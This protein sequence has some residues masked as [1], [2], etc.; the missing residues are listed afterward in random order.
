[1]ESLKKGDQRRSLRRTQVLPYAACCR[2]L[3]HLAYELVLRQ[4]VRLRYLGPD[5]SAAQLSKG[6]TVAALLGLK[7]NARPCR[8]SAV[9]PWQK[10]RGHRVAAPAFIL[11]TPRG[12][13]GEMRKCPSVTRYLSSPSSAATVIPLE[14]W[15]AREVRP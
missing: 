3:D 15:A 5:L 11:R 10:L 6:M 13:P 8:S 9:V 2:P 1:M 7:D 14:S 4:A 12:E